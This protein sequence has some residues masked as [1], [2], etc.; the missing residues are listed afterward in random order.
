M[1]D[2]C[3][4]SAFETP[5]CMITQIDPWLCR[6]TLINWRLA[7]MTS[8]CGCGIGALL[9]QVAACSRTASAFSLYVEPCDMLTMV[10]SAG[11]RDG[12]ACRAKPLLEVA[13]AHL[14]L[15]VASICN[16]GMPAESSSV[17]QTI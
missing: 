11:P 13:P 12:N 8:T 9:Q 16:L 6:Q 2:C 17:L 1:Q 4:Y 10:C 15:G 5:C 14:C 3:L 7:L